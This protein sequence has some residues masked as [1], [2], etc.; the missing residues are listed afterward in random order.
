MELKIWKI[1]NRQNKYCPRVNQLFPISQEL[2]Y[3]QTR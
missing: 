1:F 3:K 2:N